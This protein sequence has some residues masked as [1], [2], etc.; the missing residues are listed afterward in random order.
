RDI[1]VLWFL[2][3]SKNRYFKIPYRNPEYPSITLWEYNRVRA[4]LKEE[5]HSTVNEELVFDTYDRLDRLR[6]EASDATQSARKEA[7]KKRINERKATA[8]RAQVDAAHAAANGGVKAPTP[9][10]V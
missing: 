8:E 2:D 10:P 6:K 4:Q 1:S 5:G 7:Q 9:Q 3:P